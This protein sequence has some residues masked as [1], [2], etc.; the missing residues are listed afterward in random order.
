MPRKRNYDEYVNIQQPFNPWFFSG[1]DEELI[2]ENEDLRKKHD[3]LLNL[4]NTEKKTDKEKVASE[5]KTSTVKDIDEKD[6]NE[7]LKPLVEQLEESKKKDD[8]KIKDMS[9]QLEKSIEENNKLKNELKNSETEIAKLEELNNSLTKDKKKISETLNTI[10]SNKDIDVKDVD[11]SLKPL[12]EQLEE[13]KKKV[14]D[15]SSQ[16]EKSIEENNKLKNELKNSEAK[17]KFD[18][19]NQISN[20]KD[21]DESLKLLVEQ[22]EESK[23]KDDE[24]IKDMSSQLEKYIEEINSIKTEIAKL[25][26]LNNFLTKDKKKISETL[27]T[28]TS[29]KDIDVKDVDESLKPLVE[30]LKNMS[31][32]LQDTKKQLEQINNENNNQLSEIKENLSTYDNSSDKPIVEIIKNMSSELQ[33]TKK[34]L[35]NTKNQLEQSNNNQ[36]SEIKQNLS[37]YD[38]SSDKPI[39]EII[40][41]MSSELQDT[42]K[43]LEQI[44]NENNNQL[45]EIKQNLS[46]YDNSSDKPIV[47]IIKNMSSEL[48]DTKKQLQNTKNQLEQSNNEINRIKTEAE[49]KKEKEIEK[50]LNDVEK[51]KNIILFEERKNYNDKINKARQ[52][53]N[54]LQN[55]ADETIKAKD[56]EKEL[57]KQKLLKKLSELE[58]QLQKNQDNNELQKAVNKLQKENKTLKDDNDRLNK[59]VVKYTE[60][61]NVPSDINRDK[62][63]QQYIKGITNSSQEIIRNMVY[64]Q[65]GGDPETLN[66]I[67]NNKDIY[68]KDVDESLKPLVEQLKNMSTELQ[69]TK[70]QLEE[71]EES[72]KLKEKTEYIVFVKNLLIFTRLL[73]RIPFFMRLIS[74]IS[75]KGDDNK[76]EMIFGEKTK[77]IVKNVKNLYYLNLTNE[78]VNSISTSKYKEYYKKISSNLFEYNGSKFAISVEIFINKF[79]LNFIEGLDVTKPESYLDIINEVKKMTESIIET[80]NK[81]ISINITSKQYEL[82]VEKYHNSLYDKVSTF[83]RVRIDNNSINS[84]F[85]YKINKENNKIIIKYDPT[86]KQFYYETDKKKILLNP[87]YVPDDNGFINGIKKSYPIVTSYGNL[88]GIFD[89]LITNEII[90]K[91]E[92]IL[93]IINKILKLLNVFIIG[94][95]A[96]GSGKTSTLINLLLDGI[97]YPGIIIHMCNNPQILEKFDEIEL[98]F[99]ELGVNDSKTESKNKIVSKIINNDNHKTKTFTKIDGK[100]AYS[101]KT[102]FDAKTEKINKIK[103]DLKKLGIDYK[104]IKEIATFY[105]SFIELEDLQLIVNDFDKTDKFDTTDITTK[106]KNIT[107]LTNKLK[108]QN[109]K[110]IIELYQKMEKYKRDNNYTLLSE[111]LKNDIKYIYEDIGNYTVNVMETAR[112]IAATTNNPVSSRSHMLIFFKFKNKSESVNLVVLDAAGVENEFNE[113]DPFTIDAFLNVKRKGTNE[114]YYNKEEKEYKQIYIS[115]S[116]GLYAPSSK[117]EENEIITLIEKDKNILT[118]IETIKNKIGKKNKKEYIYSKDFVKLDK[119]KKNILSIT[120]HLG[121]QDPFENNF[122]PPTTFLN[123]LNTLISNIQYI[124]IEKVVAKEICKRR[125]KEGWFINDSLSKMRDFITWTLVNSLENKNLLNF[126][127]FINQCALLQCNPYFKDCFGMNSD[128][129]KRP[130][131]FIINNLLEKIGKDE[132]TLKNLNFCIFNVINLSQISANNPPPIPYIDTVDE[133]IFEL[134]KIKNNNIYSDNFKNDDLNVLDKETK[135]NDKYLKKLEMSLGISNT[136]DEINLNQQFIIP[137]KS[138]D[139]SALNP[140]VN[141]FNDD[142]YDKKINIF[143]KYF[144][145]K[146]KEYIKQIR[147]NTGT[148]DALKKLIE[149]LSNSNAVTTLGTMSY[150]DMMSK[151]GT[152]YIDCKY[153]DMSKYDEKDKKYM[154]YVQ[155]FNNIVYK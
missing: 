82:A 146:V 27:N 68:V 17:L 114:P 141:I 140:D 120:E 66:T 106:R 150:V 52:D 122:E 90:A 126:P 69:D 48:Q 113:D 143:D 72:K 138:L 39:V 7:S 44:N 67:T 119:N 35:Q 92:Q 115:K 3:E 59:N 134:Q 118:T 130:D 117:E 107:S 62:V 139:E 137:A 131:S 116:S 26:E 6:V 110:E 61:L 12:V 128:E 51:D 80:T 78:F 5:L 23:K 33:D 30:Q 41:N 13:T 2:K 74:I 43:Q 1:G 14:K 86:P 129:I 40:K 64:H 133:L 70:K 89:S 79:L 50:I 24:K 45:S 88:T 93:N 4:Y 46:T 155:Y 136:N 21:V 16:L 42:K 76:L 20:N 32:E 125:R 96:S 124:L 152:N 58:Q 151:F 111:E 54:E 85:L 31:T 38:N 36:L 127:P 8:E 153:C 75:I 53:L 112:F 60:I 102:E 28:I 108:D 57:S 148:E 97:N 91:D 87:K 104:K 56:K 95:G 135:V 55:R 9:S 147:L 29:N 65:D 154:E 94:Y 77:D 15:M 37:T 25:K 18:I 47:K 149:L 105:K 81:I 121:I 109:K 10:T 100:W 19:N 11:D 34:Q 49:S 98:S 101:N 73:C 142:V 71:N 83:L 84:R 22:L 123:G 99:V 132:N 103:E 144:I 63:K 145:D